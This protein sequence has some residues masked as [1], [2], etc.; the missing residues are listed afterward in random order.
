MS[1]SSINKKSTGLDQA[2]LLSHW[3]S[4]LMMFQGLF[5]R[6]FG[7]RPTVGGG[8]H[9]VASGWCLLCFDFQISFRI[10]VGQDIQV[11]QRELG[12]HVVAGSAILCHHSRWNLLLRHRPWVLL[13]SG[14]IRDPFHAHEIQPI[15]VNSLKTTTQAIVL[16]LLVILII[17]LQSHLALPGKSLKL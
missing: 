8:V 4:F 7:H 1:L 6:R 10:L 9:W 5:G 14:N 17:N 11:D 3:V 16:N 13:L 12:A 2:F 15:A